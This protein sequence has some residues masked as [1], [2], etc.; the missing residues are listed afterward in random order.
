MTQLKDGW[1]TVYGKSVFVENGKI[2]YG[3]TKD[4]NNSEVTCYPYEYNKDYNC[5]V[6]ISGKVTLSAYR[7]GY[8][9]GTKCMK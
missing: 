6:N 3:V 5:W 9:R 2:I 4:G 7:V 8:N 1:H